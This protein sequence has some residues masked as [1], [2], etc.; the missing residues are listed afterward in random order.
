MMLIKSPTPSEI[1]K[2]IDIAIETFRPFY[3]DYVHP[4]MGDEVF[5][6]QHGHWRGDYQRDIPTLD[7][8]NVGRHTAV[9]EIDGVV[10]GFISWRVGIKP[11]HG[12]IYLL[13]VLPQYRR[14]GVGRQLCLHAIDAMKSAGVEVVEIGTGGDAFHTPARELYES[15]DFTM[16]PV[17]AYLKRI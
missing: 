17:V 13:A 5:Q 14:M 3:E 7:A 1:P 15:L 9:S 11:R 12:E 2:L 10:A 4:L 16:I 6:H 8:P